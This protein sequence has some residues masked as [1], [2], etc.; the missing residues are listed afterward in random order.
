MLTVSSLYGGRHDRLKQCCLIRLCERL[1][2]WQTDN[3]RPVLETSTKLSVNTSR[4]K[5][6]CQSALVHVSLSTPGLHL[7]PADILLSTLS[8]SLALC[9]TLHTYYLVMLTCKHGRRA[10][11]LTWV[12]SLNLSFSLSLTKSE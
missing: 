11:I 1:C 9:T 6:L 7:R 2:E 12:I 8:P 3:R 10:P 4:V 5:Y